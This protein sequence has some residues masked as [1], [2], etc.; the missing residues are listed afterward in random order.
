M[1]S[2]KEERI[3]RGIAASGIKL[4]SPAADHMSV[5]TLNAISPRWEIW[6]RAAICSTF[7]VSPQQENDSMMSHNENS[8]EKWLI[9][10][11]SPLF[12]ISLNVIMDMNVCCSFPPPSLFVPPHPNQTSTSRREN[13]VISRCCVTNQCKFPKTNIEFC[14]H[15]EGKWSYKS[16]TA[17]ANQMYWRA[18]VECTVC[19]V[20]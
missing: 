8:Q 15:W 6:Q 19:I 1:K 3:W 17:A 11:S 9:H 13:D 2:S 14:S 18:T 5:H 7:A 20:L 4:L 12:S 16:Q 10:S